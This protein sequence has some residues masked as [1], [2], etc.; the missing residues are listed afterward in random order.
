MLDSGQVLC[1]WAMAEDAGQ[2][3]LN[4]EIG[5]SIWNYD[6]PRAIKDSFL[7]LEKPSRDMVTEALKVKGEEV[8]QGSIFG[9]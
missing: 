5:T 4:C 9:C 2:G 7:G 3:I 1:I 8:E 6:E